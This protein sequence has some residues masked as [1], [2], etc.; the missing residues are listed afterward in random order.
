MYSEATDFN[1]LPGAKAYSPWAN[2][3][4]PRP[5]SLLSLL[6]LLAKIKV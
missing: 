1:S 6:G 3:G 2:N 4:L 5:V